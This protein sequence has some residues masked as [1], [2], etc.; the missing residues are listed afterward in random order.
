MKKSIA[1]RMIE[2]QSPS[3]STG[4]PQVNLKSL[5][6]GLDESAQEIR[7]FYRDLKNAALSGD[8]EEVSI[9]ILNLDSHIQNIEGIAHNLEGY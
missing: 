3:S 1:Q 2:N 5:A 7:R 9:A 4:K 8:R 6:Q